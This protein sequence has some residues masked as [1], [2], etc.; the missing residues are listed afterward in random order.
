MDPGAGASS[1]PPTGLSAHTRATRRLD[2]G[3]STPLRSSDPRVSLV[4]GHVRRLHQ[5]PGIY[6]RTTRPTTCTA[7]PARHLNPLQSN[8]NPPR[9]HRH[10]AKKRGRRRGA[11]RNPQPRTSPPGFCFISNQQATRAASQRRPRQ[12]TP[13]SGKHTS[14]S[15]PTTLVTPCCAEWRPTRARDRPTARHCPPHRH[16]CC[17]GELHQFHLSSTLP[18]GLA[19]PRK[20]SAP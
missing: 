12:L 5:R 6:N 8:F 20:N 18:T 17:V 13:S 2:S 3:P 19:P 7:R 14:T 4:N 10:M 16:V 15:S 1:S 9:L 11:N